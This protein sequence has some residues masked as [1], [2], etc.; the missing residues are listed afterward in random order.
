[1]LP[2]SLRRDRVL[3]VA[4]AAALVAVCVAGLVAVYRLAVWTVHGRVL[5]GHALRGAIASRSR[6]TDAMERVLDVVSVASLLGA[7]ALVAVIALLRLRRGL[8]LAA[9]AVLVGAN[10]TSQLLKRVVLERPDL[11]LAERTPSTLNSM[12]SG[13]TTVAASV[14]AALVLVVPGRLRAGV[15]VAGA[16]YA[17][18]TAVAT[19][20]AGW[21]RPSDALAA[22]LVVGGWVGGAAVALLLTGDRSGPVG[23]WS[24]LDRRTAGRLALVGAALLG[25]AVVAALAA[26]LLGLQ[27]ARGPADELA[28]VAG[29]LA[30]GTATCLL[31]VAV[32][33]LTAWLTPGAAEPTE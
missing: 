2:A 1:V 20:S 13:H 30:V 14:V 4:S 29:A 10:L 5:D 16:C 23:A 17:W 15:A 7:A 12:P 22:V 3:A 31:L 27:P 33:A 6:V 26:E 25:V 18:L 32:L 8:G 28:Y 24:P 9:L 11:G 21:H 19:M